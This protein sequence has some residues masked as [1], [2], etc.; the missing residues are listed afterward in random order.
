MNTL[1]I[2][3]LII[4]LIGGLN[5]LRQGF[6]KAFANLIGWIFALIVGAKYAVVFA[7]AMAGLSQDPVVQKIAAFAFIVLIIVVCTWI[8]SAFLNGLLKSLKLGPL[9][10]LAGGAFGSLKGLLIVLITMQGLGPWVESSPHWKQSKF[11][12]VLLP[13]APLATELSKDAA[14]E[15]LH[16]MTSEGALLHRPSSKINESE[17]VLVNERSDHSTKNPFY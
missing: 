2:I 3:I 15:A 17:R 5:G 4:L 14:N 11:V 1:D 8:V 16:Q 7:P 6:I 12:Q 9:N 10:R 13:Y